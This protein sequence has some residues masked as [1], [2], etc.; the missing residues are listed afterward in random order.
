MKTGL[1]Y[2]FYADSVA[3]VGA[4]DNPGKAGNQIVKNLVEGGYQGQIYPVHPTNKEICGL[5]CYPDLL[6]IAGSIELIVIVI[7]DFGVPEVMRQA[8]KRGDIKGAVIIAAGFS[9][10]KIP[11]RIAL[12]EEV[13]ALAR[14]AGIRVFGPNCVGVINTKNNVDTTFVSHINKEFREFSFISQSGATGASIIKF[15]SDQ[16]VPFGFNKW[17]HVGNMSDV[18]ILEI[19]AYYEKDPDTKA[20]GMYMEGVENATEFLQVA[21][22]VT[23]NKPLLILK[24]GRS[25]M[26]SQAAASHT[27]SLA[28]AD[29]IY[30]GAFKQVGINRV[31][32]IDELLDAAKAFSMQPIPKGKKIC[33]LTEAGGPG[34]ICMDELG[35]SENVE[36]AELSEG[37][38]KKLQEILPPMAIV[39]RPQGYI[40]MSAAALEKAHAEALELVLAEEGVDGV[41]LISVPPTFLDSTKLAKEVV[42]VTAKHNKPVLTCLMAGDWVKDARV[43]LETKAMP[44]FD[45]PQ[46]AARAMINLVKRNDFLQKLEKEGK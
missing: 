40:D 8:A 24:V 7:S 10:T 11:E 17:A 23:K 6:S 39:N 22:R 29:R 20:I 44:T 36:M 19:L 25:E 45:L 37:C 16:P 1:D 30:E 15:A 42:K 34:I 46:R 35:L 26:G 14:E 43:L 41:I 18:D 13:L 4:T 3:I 21:K 33:V 38:V 9:E 32:T 27:G 31:S 5:T 28:G 12:E 2:F